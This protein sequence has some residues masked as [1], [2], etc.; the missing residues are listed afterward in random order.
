MKKGSQKN[1]KTR[2]GSA[3]VFALVTVIIAAM[4]LTSLLTYISSQLHFSSDRVERE[5]AFQIAEAGAYY[6]RWYLAHQIA[7]KTAEQIK[8][9]WEDTSPYPLG[10]DAPVE[11]E[12]MDPESSAI[13]K[14]M[15][16]VVKPALGSTIV[17]VKST[18]WTYAKPSI[19]R[20]VQVRF[21][22]PS[23]S[24]N[25]VLA[26]DNMRFGEGTVVTGKI[27]SNK[28]IRFDGVANNIIS[29]SLASYDD[30]DHNDTGAE[31]LE[32][33]V[34]THVTAPPGS[35]VVDTYRPLEVPPAV[36]APRTD[37]FQAGRTFPAPQLDFNSVVS[38]ISFMR[39]QATIKF[40]NTGKGRHIKLKTDGTMDVASVNSYSPYVNSFTGSNGIIN[41]SGITIGAIGGFLATNGL[42]CSSF[43]NAT[44]FCNTVATCN[45]ISNTNHNRGKCSTMTN[46]SIPNNGIV[47]V[48][49]N[50]WLEG[51]V[52]NKKVSFV[53]AELIDEPGYTGGGK[54]V[55]L[56]TG[57]LL[58]A[59]SNGLAD[60][61]D[62][63]GVIAQKNV[64]VIENSL[65][66]LTL[67]GAFLAK[68]GRVGREYYGN[69]RNTITV[70]GSIAT[71]SRYGFAYTDGTGYQ[72]RNINFD[73]N[74]LYY[75][76]PYFPTGTEYAID[77]W[78]EL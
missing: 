75:P 67:D 25:S 52:D 34:H 30:L 73:N 56:G 64:E 41:Y 15:L 2:K 37:V 4:T 45:W 22:R 48:A 70:N 23:W 19:K 1:I 60:G 55:F 42:P 57:N 17:I 50:I 63:I 28:G 33:G 6:Y 76:P 27:H 21:R 54:S 14:Y 44:T 3:L 61:S 31:K 43:T 65:D 47:F 72:N 10:V 9:F 40:D 39:S 59:N 58:Y 74:L 11:V 32:F 36:V 69:T 16:E 49:N 77:Q 46:H 7:G 71:Y 24:E 38:D 35:G 5:R 68:E 66:T 26:D 78:D 29:S 20:V 13:G 18:G 51:T 53:A 62:I 12:Y 8:D